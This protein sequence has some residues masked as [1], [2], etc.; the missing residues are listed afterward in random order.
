[1][2]NAIIFYRLGHACYK[3]RIPLILMISKIFMFLVFNSVILYTA[4]IGKQSKFAYG[5]IGCVVHSRAVI[6]ERVIIGQYTTIRRSLDPG[7]IPTIGNDVYISA[8]ERIIG[9][10]NVGNN[11][12]IGANAVV[13]KDVPDNSIVADAPAIVVKTIYTSVWDLLKN[14]EWEKNGTVK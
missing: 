8:D 1:M 14:I 6:G 9:N 11:V 12:L 13:N 7:D 4:E 2:M 3:K 5:G 10:I